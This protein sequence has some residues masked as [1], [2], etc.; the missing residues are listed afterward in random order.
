MF[1]LPIPKRISFSH[2]INHMASPTGSTYCKNH[3]PPFASIFHQETWRLSTVGEE[4]T[5]YSRG[6][7]PFLMEGHSTTSEYLG[8]PDG[9]ETIFFTAV[10]DDVLFKGWGSGT[11]QEGSR[12]PRPE[13]L[14]QWSRPV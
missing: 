2:V 5:I 6:G 1:N 8:V 11:V 9:C 13:N 3:L 7:H 10:Q 4:A 14:I 12:G